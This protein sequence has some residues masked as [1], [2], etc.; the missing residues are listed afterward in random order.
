MTG[1]K[2]LTSSMEDYL[3]AIF[4]IVS[5]KQAAKAKDIALRLNVNNSSVTGALRSLSEKGYINYAPYD[6]ITLTET[7]KVHARNVVKRHEALENF[8][9][10]ILGAAPEEAESTACKME[11]SISPDI[12]ERLIRFVRFIENC[13]RG[14]EDWLKKF[15]EVCRGDDIQRHCQECLTTCLEDAREKAL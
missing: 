9:I 15:T 1:I 8:F 11:H 7:G 14:G 4:H 13:P 5:K 3:E 12:L 10:R 2:A 6:L